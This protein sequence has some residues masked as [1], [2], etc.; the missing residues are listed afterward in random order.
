MRRPRTCSA[1]A[2]TSCWGRVRSRVVPLPQRAPSVAAAEQAA[3]QAAEA[4]A[5]RLEAMVAGLKAIVWERDPVTLRFRY[6]SSRAEE[7]LGYRTQQWLD[8]AG[9]WQRILHPDDREEAMRLVAD[10]IAHG[11]DYELSYRL[12]SRDGRW[13]WLRHLAHVARDD[14]GVPRAVHAVLVD[15][16]EEKRR[17]E[18]AALLAATGGVLSGPGTVE[19]RLGAVAAL[20]AGRICDQAAV[21]LRGDD[22]RLRPIA[23]APDG[24]LLG[25]EPMTLPPFRGRGAGCR[26]AG[27]RGGFAGAFPASTRCEFP[28]DGDRATG[29]GAAG[30]RAD[31][32]RG[33][34]PH[35]A[36][37][38]RGTSPW[39]GSSGSGWGRWSPPNGWPTGSGSCTTSPSRCP[40]PAPRRRRPRWPAQGCAP[41]SRRTSSP[42]LSSAT[43]ACST[44]PEPSATRARS[45]AR[46]RPCVCRRPSR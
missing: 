27:P 1:G 37:R 33:D 45:W 25:S 4:N 28:V 11:G 36:Q 46:S 29:R 7:L 13:V 34:R 41:C 26:T 32:P 43:T 38:R 17:E 16:T 2:G 18:A 6:V 14:A 24:G 35:P 21:W 20:A 40:P 15:V 39:P 42:W 23:A 9:L 30:G 44:W 12:R 19:D 3:R 8:D 31:H 22:D 5:A 10:G